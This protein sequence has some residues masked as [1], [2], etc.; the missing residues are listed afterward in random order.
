MKKLTRIKLINWHLF[1]HQDIEIRDNVLI[2]G[3]NGVGKSTLLDALQYVLIGEKKGVKFNIAANDIAKRSLES[4]IKGKLGLENKEFL[5]NK[6]VITHIA[7][8]FYDEIKEEY[9]ILGCVLELPYKGLLKDKFYLFS[10]ISLNKNI[11]IFDNQIRNIKN[12]REYFRTL[13]KNFD[14]FDTKQQYRNAVGKFLDI[15]ISK[16][17]KILPKALAFKPLNLQQFIFDFL[18]EENPINVNSLKN[19]VQQLKKIEFQMEIEKKKLKELTKII[20]IEK[21]LKQINNQIKIHSLSE[22]MLLVHQKEKHLNKTLIQ[23]ELIEKELIALISQKQKYNETIEQLNDYILKLQ[24]NKIQNKSGSVLYTLQ[25]DLVNKQRNFEQIQDKID[26]LNKQLKAEM[27]ILENLFL[28]EKEVILEEN[29]HT[30]N[31]FLTEPTK[32]NSILLQT[33]FNKT[34][35]YFSQKII[36]INIVQNNLKKEILLLQ[37]EINKNS[38]ELEMINKSYI[39]NNN[40]FVKINNLLKEKLNEKYNKNI[41]VYPLCELIEVKDELWRN[42]IEGFLGSRKFNL[43]IDYRYFDFALKIYEKLQDNLKIYDVGLVNT[44]KIP[45][46]K[47]NYD[48]LASYIS[49]ENKDALKYIKI[50][51]SNIKCELNMA[52]LKNHKTAITPSGMIYS[53]YTAKKLNPKTYQIPYIGV[54]SYKIRQ[55]IILNKMNLQKEELMQKQNK[56]RQND[57]ILALIQKSKIFSIINLDF[58]SLLEQKQETELNLVNIKDKINKL[59]LD[60]NLTQLE[61]NI[62]Q[63]QEESQTKK[64]ELENIMFKIS[65]NKNKENI[66]VNQIHNLEKELFKYKDELLVEEPKEIINIEAASVQLNNYLHEY[67]NNYEIIFKNIQENL[68]NIE[69][70]KNILKLD[71]ISLM[72]IY[73]EDYN[74]LNVE[75]K[76]EN[77]V[78]FMK[79]YNLINSKNLIQY[80]Q[81]AKELSIKTEIIFKE[82][83]INKLKKSIIETKQQIDNLNQILQNRPFGNDY[84]QIITKPSDDIEY[85]KYYSFFIKDDKSEEMNL[86]HENDLSYKDELLNELFRKIMSFEKEYENITYQFLDYR[87]YLDYDIKIYDKEGNFSFFSKIFREKSGGETQIPFYIIM[88]ICFEQLLVDNSKSK[89]CLV[90]FDEAFNNMDENRI[91]AMMS[92]FNNLRIQFFIAIPP[93][94]IFN[95]LPYV[96]TNLIVVKEN[97]YAIIESFIKDI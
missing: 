29:Y 2:S 94:R 67:H 39:S 64:Q 45:D 36:N 38:Y 83:F 90:F 46:I 47:D 89:S 32:K 11:F 81:E 54:N 71:L 3:E 44:E 84:Y 6:N 25:M 40:H 18:L 87:N 19:N 72:K 69:Y 16:Y 97:N 26:I 10:G 60:V 57:T 50:L 86:L 75:P 17:L 20:E 34:Y 30:I 82:E 96:N 55:N 63:L 59:S 68:K 61:N 14:F 76:L 66:Y 35:N 23:K 7:L 92:F 9:T 49:S 52:N 77:F 85:Q 51:L 58:V 95:I 41:F 24:T 21:N 31:S 78:F 74:L 12:M 13:D 91:D 4:Y 88:A 70:Q 43:I 80:E 5:R 33:N 8:E 62:V 65:E 42:A 22:K 27:S 56:F 93:Q 53:N 73:I 48:S 15:N 37:N 79:E 1:S 28:L